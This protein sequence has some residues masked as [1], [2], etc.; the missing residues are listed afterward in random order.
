MENTHTLSYDVSSDSGEVLK[1]CIL[2]DKNNAIL[3]IQAFSKDNPISEVDLSEK[4][5]E[6]LKTY[7]ELMLNSLKNK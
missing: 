4:D 7:T 5:I 6:I 3:K 2:L 1:A